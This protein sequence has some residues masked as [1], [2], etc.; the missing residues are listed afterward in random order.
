MF[1]T[2]FKGIVAYPSKTGLCG[3]GLTIP[4]VVLLGRFVHLCTDCLSANQIAEFLPYFIQ[5]TIIF[6]TGLYCFIF[7]FVCN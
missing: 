2:I 6:I 5:Y 4:A 3:C 7:R 1:H